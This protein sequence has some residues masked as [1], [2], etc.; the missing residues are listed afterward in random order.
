MFSGDGAESFHRTGGL[1]G[2]QRLRVGPARSKRP[3]SPPAEVAARVQALIVTRGAEGSVIYT[4]GPD[5][6]RSLRQAPAP[7][8]IRP[9]AGMPIGLV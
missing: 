7:S 5:A 8:S 4:A 6:G 1:G 3:A 9:V 2:G